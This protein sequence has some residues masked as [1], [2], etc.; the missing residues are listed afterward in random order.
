MKLQNANYRGTMTYA[1]V[2]IWE[3]TQYGVK[4]RS[5]SLC[6]EQCWLELTIT[7]DMKEWQHCQR[8]VLPHWQDL[9]WSHR[10]LVL[11]PE[12]RQVLFC[13]MN[14]SHFWHFPFWEPLLSPPK[15]TRGSAGINEPKHRSHVVWVGGGCISASHPVGFWDGSTSS[16]RTRSAVSAKWCCCLHRWRSSASPA[17]RLIRALHLPPRQR[18]FG[19]VNQT[20]PAEEEGP[21]AGQSSGE[22]SDWWEDS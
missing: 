9:I 13:W 22:D 17:S 10:W 6:R 1:V 7:T 12:L 15:Q 14:K 18:C 5:L 3:Q 21:D 20:P 19:L 4:S 11:D 16:T 8:V 2:K